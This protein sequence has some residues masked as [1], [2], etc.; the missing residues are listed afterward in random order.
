MDNDD[1]VPPSPTVNQNRK[2]KSRNARGR[3]GLIVSLRTKKL[4]NKQNETTPPIV[5]VDDEIERRNFQSNTSGQT[6]KSKHDESEAEN[7]IYLGYGDETDDESTAIPSLANYNIY[8]NAK[9]LEDAARFD[10][11]QPKEGNRLQ[12]HAFPE[13]FT[14]VTDFIATQSTNSTTPTSINSPSQSLSKSGESSSSGVFEGFD[15]NLQFSEWTPNDTKSIASLKSQPISQPSSQS[16]NRKS[17]ETSSILDSILN[18]FSLENS[19]SQ[20]LNETI[21]SPPRLLLNKQNVKTYIQSSKPIETKRTLIFHDPSTEN[22]E[23]SLNINNK[24]DTDNNLAADHCIEDEDI[25]LNASV[26]FLEN[27]ANLGTFLTQSHNHATHQISLDF[28]TNLSQSPEC[29][30]SIIFDE[31]SGKIIINNQFLL[32]L[33]F[34]KLSKIFFVQIFGQ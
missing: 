13:G 23:N 18:D 31:M 15:E 11:S 27:I 22:D 30:E 26:C 21:N 17:N 10:F 33:F 32:L 5:V 19:Q 8:S 12:N 24:S 4:L 7:I 20:D 9:A 34:K 25:D 1:I 16:R 6:E 2:R 3:N 29:N 14:T 28:S